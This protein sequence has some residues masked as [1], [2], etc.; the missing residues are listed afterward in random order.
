MLTRLPL[1]LEDGTDKSSLIEQLVQRH[2]PDKT[3][4]S[5]ILPLS[6]PITSLQH[7]DHS[8]LL[9]QTLSAAAIRA[10][11]IF[12]LQVVEK[13]LSEKITDA[14]RRALLLVFT[15]QLLCQLFG[16]SI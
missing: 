13:L 8:E 11:G 6:G 5:S 14:N 2:M 12:N 10:T 9:Q 3:H 16:L 4:A 15:T 1:H 7:I